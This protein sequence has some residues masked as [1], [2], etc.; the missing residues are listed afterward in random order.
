MNEKWNKNR[1]V[2]ST[3]F[4]YQETRGIKDIGTNFWNKGRTDE[5]AHRYVH[6]TDINKE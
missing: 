4:K 2:Q 6:L 1:I 3:P 5:I